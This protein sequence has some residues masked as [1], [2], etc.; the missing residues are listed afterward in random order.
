MRALIHQ[1]AGWKKNERFGDGLQDVPEEVG[2][3][4]VREFV[5]EDDFK[6]VGAERSD[7]AERKQHDGA[8]RSHRHGAV[9]GVGEAKSNGARKAEGRRDALE[10]GSNSGGGLSGRGEAQ[11][12]EIPPA[13]K[14]A[15]GKRKDAEEPEAI[16]PWKQG[17]KRE[18]FGGWLDGCKTRR[19]G[20]RE[21]SDESGAKV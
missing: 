16:N 10:C 12:A 13:A 6:F 3:A 5:G 4:H 15:H 9:N 2:A 20:T 18:V 21:I 11:S 1:T 8:Q 7:G 17:G 19:G 14:A